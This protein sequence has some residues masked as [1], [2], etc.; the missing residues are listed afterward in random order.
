MSDTRSDI[1]SV[2]E[3]TRLVAAG[4]AVVAVHFLRRTAVFV[5]SEEALVF[6]EPDGETRRMAIHGGAILATAA[7]GERIVSGG[8]DGKVVTTDT[9]SSRVLAMDPKHRWIDHI[10][11]GRD[12]AIAWSAGK[13]VFVQA[14]TLRT[15]EAPSTVGGLAFLPKGFRLAMAHYNGATLWF[16]NA[17]QA[18]PERLEWKGSHLGATVSPDGHFLVTTM[19]EPVLHGWRLSDGEHIPM[20]GYDARV[21]SLSWS[22]GG[23]WLA[24]SGATQL[25]LW[26]FHGKDGP[27]GKTPRLLTPTD[28]RIDV[29]ACHPRKAVVAAGYGNG[30]ILLTRIDNA[31][32]LAKNVGNAPVSA[33]AWSADGLLLA[34]GTEGGEAG[35]IDIP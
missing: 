24:T 4:G 9:E 28:Y 12:G 10:A 15:F 32:I 18:E 25:V 26:P 35:V 30:L 17:L 3:R 16:P 6:A 33:L 23:E 31:I 5:L 11:L 27:M 20:S 7:D 29:V 1:V 34:W 13:S 22:A 2:V 14:K 19:Q 21:R 8:D